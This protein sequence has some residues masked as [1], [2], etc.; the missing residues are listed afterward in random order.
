MNILRYSLA[1]YK[2]K[3]HRTKKYQKTEKN[4]IGKEHIYIYINYILYQYPATVSIHVPPPPC[5][6]LLLPLPLPPN[7]PPITPPPPPP[8]LPQGLGRKAW[9]PL[10]LPNN[11]IL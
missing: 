9:W 4:S 7:A 6:T 11:H 2:A 10:K 3:C 5:P 8:S 1:L